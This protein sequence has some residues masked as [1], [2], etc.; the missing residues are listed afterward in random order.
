MPWMPAPNPTAEVLETLG[1]SRPGGG[2]ETN[3]EAF[4]GVGRK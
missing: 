4:A 3:R 1:G 2:F